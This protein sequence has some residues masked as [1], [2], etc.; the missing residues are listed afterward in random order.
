MYGAMR[1]LVCRNP[2]CIFGVQRLNW[3]L[4]HNQLLL[5]TAPPQREYLV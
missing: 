2:Q 4:V 1:N 3:L 5:G